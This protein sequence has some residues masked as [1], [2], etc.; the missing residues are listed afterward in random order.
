M[1]GKFIFLLMCGI[2]FL[3]SACAFTKDVSSNETNT[4]T[5][6][7]ES[8]DDL[9]TTEKLGFMGGN[10]AAGGLMAGD[11]NGWIYYRSEANG[12]KLY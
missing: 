10:I 3:L 2:A 6:A 4:D 8:G 9:P 11:G 7:E 1:K 5:V 12:W